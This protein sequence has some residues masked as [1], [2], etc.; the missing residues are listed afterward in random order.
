MEIIFLMILFTILYCRFISLDPVQADLK[1]LRVK[2]EKPGVY[3]I[4]TP[5]LPK[6]GQYKH[7]FTIIH[8]Q[9]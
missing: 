1:I 8:I 2:P 7:S 6:N 4:H 5:P 9:Y 3:N